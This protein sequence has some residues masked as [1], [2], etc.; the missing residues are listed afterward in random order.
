MNE[1][2][3][4]FFEKRKVNKFLK[5]MAVNKCLDSQI[6]EYS[7]QPHNNFNEKQIA[8]VKKKV[9]EKSGKRS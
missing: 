8:Y 2:I 6:L 4:W 7:K 9:G 1:I 3:K 5:K